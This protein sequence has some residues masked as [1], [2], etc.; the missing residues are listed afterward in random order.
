[1]NPE[2][3]LNFIRGVIRP[4]LAFIFPTAVVAIGIIV[5][6]KLLPVAVKFIDRDIALVIV[7]TVLTI[8]TT[9]TGAASAIVFFYYGERS[10]KKKEEK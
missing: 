4:Y 1:M 6:L 8:V 5:A 9:I 3:W 2:K 10:G 7:V